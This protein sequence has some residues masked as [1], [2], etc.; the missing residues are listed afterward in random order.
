M[1]ERDEIIHGGRRECDLQRS[2]WA[3]GERFRGQLH[4]RLKMT[5]AWGAGPSVG[6]LD[7]GCSLTSSQTLVCGR[8]SYCKLM[9]CIPTLFDFSIF[10]PVLSSLIILMHFEVRDEMIKPQIYSKETIYRFGQWRHQNCEVTHTVFNKS[11]EP[12]KCNGIC[13]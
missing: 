4:F 2:Q 13:F 10:V 9:P 3:T 5:K 11:P 6:W 8:I 7:S 1:W 12:K